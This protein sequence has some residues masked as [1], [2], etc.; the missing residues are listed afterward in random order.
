MTES[1]ADRDVKS[2]N[3]IFTKASSRILPADSD[4]DRPAGV[5]LLG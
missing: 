4:I 2:V 1:R 5:R 3:V